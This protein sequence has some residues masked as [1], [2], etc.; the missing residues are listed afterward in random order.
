M[1]ESTSPYAG[2]NL[3]VDGWKIFPDRERRAFHVVVGDSRFSHASAQEGL[4]FVVEASPLSANYNPREFN[5][6]LRAFQEQWQLVDWEEIP[7]RERHIARRMQL[8][9]DYLRNGESW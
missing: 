1:S 5:R 4:R 3:T 2:V 9:I 8:I 7:E 6:I